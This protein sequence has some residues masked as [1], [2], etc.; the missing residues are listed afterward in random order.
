MGLTKSFASVVAIAQYIHRLAGLGVIHLSYRPA[1]PGT[2]TAGA[3]GSSRYVP[4]RSETAAEKELR[5]ARVGEDIW[6]RVFDAGLALFQH[7]PVV[8]DLQGLLGILLDEQNGD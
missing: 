2:A 1:I 8:G 7:Q 4:R 6:R 3:P 5:D